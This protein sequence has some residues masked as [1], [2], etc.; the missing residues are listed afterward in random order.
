MEKVST[1][2][3][4]PS[5]GTMIRQQITDTRI[6]IT[7][8]KQPIKMQETPVREDRSRQGLSALPSYREVQVR[9]EQ[10]L[11]LPLIRTHIMIVNI[12]VR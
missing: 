5:K 8:I 6:T 10:H 3:K 12:E 11:I 9:M 7:T 2:M 4:M 1:E